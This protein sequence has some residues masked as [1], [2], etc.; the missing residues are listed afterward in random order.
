MSNIEVFNRVVATV[1]KEL[2]SSFPK[3]VFLKA[4][5]LRVAAEI[6]DDAWWEVTR[7]ANLNPVGCALIWLH[8][9]GFIRYSDEAGCSVFANVVLTAKGFAALNK[10]PESLASKPTIGERLKELSKTAT[11]ETVSNLVKIA[12]SQA[13]TGLA[14]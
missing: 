8:D 1:F 13:F 10:S 7:G 3:P 5:E 9:E 6:T 2:Y 4:A 14:Q 11:S 12:L